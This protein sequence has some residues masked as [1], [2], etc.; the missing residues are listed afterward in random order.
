MKGPLVLLSMSGLG[1]VQG[2]GGEGLLC[3]TDPLSLGTS[4]E[5]GHGEVGGTC[6]EP[7]THTGW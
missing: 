1:H 3:G 7:C 5:V 6:T 4:G 2:A